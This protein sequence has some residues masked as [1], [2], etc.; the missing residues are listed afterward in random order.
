MKR[1]ILEILTLACLITTSLQAQVIP[2]RWEKVEAQK[3]G[4]ELT[5]IM[6]SGDRFDCNFEEL[7]MD[8]LVVE[9]GAG[10]QRIPKVDVQRLETLVP[11][12]VKDG[13]VKGVVIGAVVGGVLGGVAGASCSGFCTIDNPAL[14]V[15]TVGAVIGAGVGAAIGYGV[16]KA[17]DNKRPEVLYIAR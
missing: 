14:V 6:K 12:S 11:D 9:T 8:T 15:G 3:Q 4:T 10:E 7:Q 13:T 5:V 2:G 16:D 17:A 1:P